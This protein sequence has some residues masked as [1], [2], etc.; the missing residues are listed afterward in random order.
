[1][2]QVEDAGHHL[3]SRQHAIGVEGVNDTLFGQTERAG[4]GYA[5][6]HEEAEVVGVDGRG[7]MNHPTCL[8]VVIE[9]QPHEVGI[10][11]ERLTMAL[12]EHEAVQ[13]GHRAS[14]GPAV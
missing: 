10:V 8:I 2:C 9:R 7:T 11:I 5:T 1:M 13:Q 3:I 4:A 14:K 12:F 6:Q